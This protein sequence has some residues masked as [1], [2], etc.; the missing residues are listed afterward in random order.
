MQ[1]VVTGEILGEPDHIVSFQEKVQLFFNIPAKFLHQA[2]GIE[3][4]K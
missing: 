2:G 4:V 1:T 3:K